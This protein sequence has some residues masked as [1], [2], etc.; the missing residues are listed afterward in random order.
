MYNQQNPGHFRWNWIPTQFSDISCKSSDVK[1]FVINNVVI[2][3]PHW[4]CIWFRPIHPPTHLWKLKN[5]PCTAWG[6][7]LE[8]QLP[9][10]LVP[11]DE[12]AHPNLSWRWIRRVYLL[13]MFCVI[14]SE[15]CMQICLQHKFRKQPYETRQHSI[16]SDTNIKFGWNWKGCCHNV[17]L[18]YG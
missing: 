11:C 12:G 17:Y 2:S 13:C 1:R 10:Q 18:P 6:M 8:L 3:L 5:L 15:M 7:E 16:H 14:S 4:Y 9:K